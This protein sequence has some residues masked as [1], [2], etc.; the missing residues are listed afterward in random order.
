M[1]ETS[2]QNHTIQQIQKAQIKEI[3]FCVKPINTNDVRELTVGIL[4]IAIGRYS[5][6]FDGF[7]ESCK[8]RLFPGVKKNFYVY[9][10]CLIV[11][12]EKFED[13]QLFHCDD[14]G[15]PENTLF[16]FKLFNQTRQFWENNDYVIFFNGNT[17]F[18]SRIEFHE[19]FPL[20]CQPLTMLSW[21][22]YESKSPNEY[23]YDRNPSCHAYIPFGQGVRYFQGGLIAAGKNEF[24]HIV[25]YCDN[26]IKEDYSKGIIA[27]NHDESQ[28]NRYLLDKNPKVLS[29]EYGRPQ[30]WKTPLNPKIIFR[31]KNA[32]LGAEYIAKLKNCRRKSLI[33]RILNSIF[34]K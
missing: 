1:S 5:S 3:E 11:E 9:S 19:F 20:N 25:E 10:D 32:L 4:Y 22:I 24:I 15:W 21:H 18:E 29:T 2:I 6:F 27:I 28:L 13:V 34:K 7:Y 8:K 33:K 26:A 23:P 12:K 17:Y 31:D 16:R 14:L 30:E